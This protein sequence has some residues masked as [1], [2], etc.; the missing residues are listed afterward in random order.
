VTGGGG[1]PTAHGRVG[2]ISFNQQWRHS[3]ASATSHSVSRPE[4]VG[5]D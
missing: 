5:G 2:G 4:V 1:A 3:A